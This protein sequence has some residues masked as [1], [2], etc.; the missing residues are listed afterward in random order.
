MA[1]VV[2][3]VSSFFWPVKVELPTEGGKYEKHTFDV[4]FKKCSTT[5]I[6]DLMAQIKSEQIAD[7]A[8]LAKIVIVNWRG[9][10][11]SDG[12]E[13][14]FSDGALSELLDIPLVATAIVQAF[15]ESH[16]KGPSKN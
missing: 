8:A 5:E 7:D 16:S 1:F 12:S 13:M 6:K 15:F 9:V 2:K 4:E 10:Q 11:N 3:K 14:K